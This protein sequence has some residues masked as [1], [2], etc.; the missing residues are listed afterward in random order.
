MPAFEN[1][2]VALIDQADFDRKPAPFHARLML[3]A[4]DLELRLQRVVLEH[5]LAERGL[6]LQERDHRGFKLVGKRRG[7]ERG[8]RHQVQAMDDRPAE[9][10]GLGVFIVVVQRMGVA[11]ERGKAKDIRLGDRSRAA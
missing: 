1:D 8:E 2:F 7:A 9:P 6:L 10:R 3:G 4:F 11:G 5:R